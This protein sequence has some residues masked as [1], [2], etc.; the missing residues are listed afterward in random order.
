MQ[1]IRSSVKGAGVD[2]EDVFLNSGVSP[3]EFPNWL[4]HAAADMSQ[5]LEYS[6][7]GTAEQ[8]WLKFKDALQTGN[9]SRIPFGEKWNLAERVSAAGEYYSDL[10]HGEMLDAWNK[11]KSDPKR[12]ADLMAAMPPPPKSLHRQH[13]SSL[14]PP[15]RIPPGRVW[16]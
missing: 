6:L 16:L 7:R 13:K 1:G 14:A 11:V 8:K 3:G 9:Y 12:F 15:L 10:W 2:V 5:S 4:Q